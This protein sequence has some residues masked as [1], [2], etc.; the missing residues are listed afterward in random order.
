MCARACVFFVNKSEFVDK[1]RHKLSL[2]F[3]DNLFVEKGRKRLI[4][5]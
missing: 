3:V 2:W 4:I 5:A 1:K